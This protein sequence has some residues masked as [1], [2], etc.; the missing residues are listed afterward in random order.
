MTKPYKETVTLYEIVKDG[1]S[2]GFDPEQTRQDAGDMG[3]DITIDSIKTSW[4]AF[5]DD[6]DDY[7]RND[8]YK[9]NDDGWIEA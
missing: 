3:Y 8:P 4:L 5:Q 9:E 7:F 1:W 6:M 2:R